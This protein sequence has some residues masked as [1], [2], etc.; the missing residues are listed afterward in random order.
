MPWEEVCTSRVLH[1]D[2]YLVEGSF[3]GACARKMD[4]LGTSEGADIERFG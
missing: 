3:S 2:C 1:A 4:E